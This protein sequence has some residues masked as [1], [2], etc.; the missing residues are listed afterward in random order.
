MPRLAHMALERV[1]SFVRG[2]SIM[3]ISF[4][5]LS[6]PPNLP[7]V[8]YGAEGQEKGLFL[9]H[10]DGYWH[11]L[12]EAGTIQ[13]IPNDEADPVLVTEASAN[14]QRLEDSVAAVGQQ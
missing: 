13:A 1:A 14:S 5:G 6:R 4:A 8:T 9:G 11:M 10:S 2:M 7:V 3:L 12:D